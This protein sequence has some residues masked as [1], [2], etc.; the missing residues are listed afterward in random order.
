M[1]IE[2]NIGPGTSEKMILSQGMGRRISAWCEEGLV[3]P[4]AAEYGRRKIE[5]KSYDLI[6]MFFCWGRQQAEDIR[7]GLGLEGEKLF[8]TGNPRFDLHRADLRGILAER[9]QRIKDR[10]AP[11]ILINTRFSRY[12]GY[13]DQPAALEKLRKQGRVRNP[14]DEEEARSLVAFHGVGYARFMELT[15]QLSRHFSDYTI[16]VRPH[17][18]ERTDPWKAKAATLPNVQVV[19]EGN[20]AE[21]L[22]ASEICIHTNCTT[23][24]EAYLLGRK[25]ISYRPL[26]HTPFDLFLPNFLSADA[27]E[28][29]AVIDLV[30][31]ALR[32]EDLPTAADA[33]SMGKTAHRFI[34]NVTGKRAC[35]SIMDALES[36]DLREEPFSIRA[37]PLTSVKKAFGRMLFAGE[38]PGVEDETG[39][40]MEL[41]NAAQKVTG[42]YKNIQIAE[43]DKSLLCVYSNDR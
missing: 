16:V 8:I 43:I 35:T 4:D 33:Y 24:V 29:G 9:V 5:L 28:L 36:A 27:F 11:F 21:W 42:K 14:E 13:S 23:G 22:L 20:V 30:A 31:K 17:P 6:D 3:Y 19:R 32:G 18:A 7:D 34:E 26:R 25:S 12:N 40:L 2:K 38:M 39:E 10:Y 41:L 15:E 1:L 37:T